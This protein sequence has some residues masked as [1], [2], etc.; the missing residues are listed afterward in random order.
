MTLDEISNLKE[1]WF[2]DCPRPSK[3]AIARIKKFVDFVETDGPKSS[4][5][6]PDVEG[7]IAC[8]WFEGK[9]FAYVVV[10]NDGEWVLGFQS[11]DLER[12][13]TECFGPDI[14]AAKQAI[15]QWMEFE[16]LSIELNC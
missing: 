6:V 1:G 7:G 15:K 4:K 14:D 13:Y 5:Y 12:F 8:Y 2:D 3:K 10:F 11:S 9:R 16:Q